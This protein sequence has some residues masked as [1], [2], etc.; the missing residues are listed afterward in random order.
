MFYLFVHLVALIMLTI[1]KWGTSQK[2]PP[3]PHRRIV[4][5]GSNAPI[6][7]MNLHFLSVYFF[8]FQHFH[9]RKSL[10]QIQIVLNQQLYGVL[11]VHIQSNI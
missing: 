5:P 1:H 8:R 3:P 10:I 4:A 11:P 9:A 7:E 6:K 2:P